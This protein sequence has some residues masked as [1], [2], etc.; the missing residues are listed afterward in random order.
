ML[1]CH[2]FCQN[3]VFDYFHTHTH[4]H[5]YIYN[6]L[7]IFMIIIKHVIVRSKEKIYTKSVTKY[8]VYT[9]CYHIIS[10]KLIIFCRIACMRACRHVKVFEVKLNPAPSHSFFQ[11]KK[12]PPR[13]GSERRKQGKQI[14]R[15]CSCLSEVK[16]VNG[17][18]RSLNGFNG[19]LKNFLIQHSTVL[20]NGSKQLN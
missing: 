20:F 15:C 6:K 16:I 5:T 12:S 18:F 4:T 1:I 17:F 9:F 11:C 19:K 3:V 2:K 13:T 7:F 8:Y 14:C 10:N